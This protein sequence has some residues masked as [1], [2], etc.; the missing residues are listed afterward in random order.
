MEKYALAWQPTKFYRG[1][2]P[3]CGWDRKH[4]RAIVR[5]NNGVGE[6]PDYPSIRSFLSGDRCQQTRTFTKLANPN[7]YE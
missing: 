7:S 1:N 4:T 5:C 6:V 2:L 3:A